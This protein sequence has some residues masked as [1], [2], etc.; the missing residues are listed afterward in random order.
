MKTI[1]LDATPMGKYLYELLGFKEETTLGRY[2]MQNK[3]NKP[4]YSASVSPK[5]SIRK[6]SRSE[7]KDIISI[8]EQLLSIS[9][10]RIL[11]AFLADNIENTYIARSKDGKI[12]G[13]LTGR[14]GKNFFQI[15]PLVGSGVETAK[16]LLIRALC[17]HVDKSL[18]IDIYGE[19][20]EFISFVKKSGA[21]EGRKFTRMYLG[22]EY[23]KRNKKNEYC[24]SGP[25]KG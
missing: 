18:G 10:R 8:D 22:L 21:L 9:R 5:N 11:N 19:N 16:R 6:A 12:E 4:K 25:E 14:N 17:L 20:D 23:N 1:K 13:Y 7:I 24:T 3:G 2:F 15:G